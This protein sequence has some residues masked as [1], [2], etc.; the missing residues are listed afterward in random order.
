M[1]N[2][3]LLF[4]LLVIILFYL[5]ACEEKEDEPQP[6]TRTELLTAKPWKMNKILG[7]GIDVTNNPLLP[8][9]LKDMRVKFDPDGS[10]TMTSVIGSQTGS[11]AFAD[12]E[13]QLVLDP[14]T[15]DEVTW[16][17]EELKE[18]S[19]TFGIT[20]DVPPVGLVMFTVELVHP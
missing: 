16:E 3:L 17:V 19:A 7:N 6:A 2:P 9:N 1:K 15:A 13:T 4:R 12:K 11:W 10:Y 5:T 8:D 20:S 14:K 18:N